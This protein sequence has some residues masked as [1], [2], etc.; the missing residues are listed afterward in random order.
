MPEK[1]A[2]WIALAG[3]IGAIAGAVVSGVF[4]YLTHRGD[5]D[6]KMIELSVGILRA[7]PT[8][9]TTPLREWAIDVIDKRA[10]FEFDEAQRAALLKQ[11]LPFKGVAQ[12]TITIGQDEQL[13]AALKAISEQ[14]KEARREPVS[15]Q[16]MK[17]MMELLQKQSK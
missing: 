14:I 16:Q 15:E 3:T 7:A 2:G 10:R 5:L 1:S 9:E 17:R 11:E 12:S 6:A 8:P 4:N 13:S